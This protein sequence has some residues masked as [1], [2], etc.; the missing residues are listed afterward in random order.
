MPFDPRCWTRL[1][2]AG[3]PIWV[4]PDRPDWLVPNR[5]GD[6]VLRG[7]AGREPSGLD[8]AAQRFLRRLP[9]EAA[10][11]YEGRHALLRTDHLRELWFHVTD[12]CN[13]TCEHCLVSSSP[14]AVRALEAGRIL[15]LARQASALGCRI[16][17]LSGGEP[18]VHRE[19][20]TIVDGLLALDGA[21]VAVLTN[22]SRL[23]RL[24]EALARWPSERFHLQVSL[25]GMRESHDRLRGERAF[26]R[27]ESQLRWLHGEGRPF[28]LSMCVM[29]DNRD[30]MADL[31]DLAADVGASHVHFLWYFVRGRAAAAGFG[32]PAAI[33]ERLLAAVE[34][35]ERRGIAIDN[36]E[37]IRAQVF[38]PAGT[39]HDAGSSGW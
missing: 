15:D 11:E 8:L 39:L 16:F 26:D 13:M 5:A 29:R 10:R 2:H 35:A 30:E 23:R 17:A 31:V 34:R 4:R 27:L 12:H 6:A 19:F 14:E 37:A 21:R 7:L 28:S 33:F 24:G 9:D 25:D 22:G 36:I 38:S 18:T 1:E 3:V 20:E 32:Q